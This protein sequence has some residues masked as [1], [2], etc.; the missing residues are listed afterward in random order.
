MFKDTIENYMRELNPKAYQTYLKKGTL[1]T[2]IQKL[3]EWAMTEWLEVYKPMEEMFLQSKQYQEAMKLPD[4]T[5]D[6]LLGMVKLQAKEIVREDL[7]AMIR[8][9]DSSSIEK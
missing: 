4:M 2:R 7:A 1:Q 9:E 8:N 6:G 3:N 5:T